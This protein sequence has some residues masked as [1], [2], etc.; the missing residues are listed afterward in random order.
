M[1]VSNGERESVPLCTPSHVHTSEEGSETRDTVHV[2]AHETRGESQT[3][4]FCPGAGAAADAAAPSVQDRRSSESE[5]REGRPAYYP[6]HR[7]KLRHGGESRARAHA[8]AIARAEARR[9]DLAHP[10]QRYP[11][12]SSPDVVHPGGND[13]H[14]H[15]CEQQST[16]QDAVD[17]MQQQQDGEDDRVRADHADEEQ[18][19][20]PADEHGTD[21]RSDGEV[22]RVLHRTRRRPVSGSD[23]AG[24]PEEELETGLSSLSS[25]TSSSLSS[26][27]SSSSS[28]CSCSSQQTSKG[29]HKTPSGSSRTKTRRRSYSSKQPSSSKTELSKASRDTIRH[30]ERSRRRKTKDT[31]DRHCQH[32]SSRSSSSISSSS[33]RCR[34][35]SDRAPDAGSRAAQS[36]LTVTTRCSP[37]A[38]IS[39]TPPAAA[40]SRPRSISPLVLRSGSE[41]SVP[42]SCP[43]ASSE[44]ASTLTCSSS[45]CSSS[46]SSSSSVSSDLAAS[47]TPPSSPRTVT[48]SSSALHV[49]CQT[50]S[51]SSSCVRGVSRQSHL[52]T[53]TNARVVNSCDISRSAMRG[54]LER[55]GRIT[56]SISLV[57]PRSC[58]SLLDLPTEIL[59]HAF[60]Y[61][62]AP[63]LCALALVNHELYEI[64]QENHLWRRV[65]ARHWGF[66]AD[67]LKS[68]HHWKYHFRL[69]YRQLTQPREK[70]RKIFRLIPHLSGHSPRGRSIQEWFRNI[71]QQ[72]HQ[73]WN[74]K[75]DFS[76]ALSA[77]RQR[78]G[79]KITGPTP[80]ILRHADVFFAT[81]P[82]V[83][84]AEIVALFDSPTL[85]LWINTSSAGGLDGGW[86]LRQKLPFDRALWIQERSPP[87]AALKEWARRHRIEFVISVDRDVG[88]QPRQTTFRFRLPPGTPLEQ[89]RVA[90]HAFSNFGYPPLPESIHHT[91]LR[92]LQRNNWSS[93]TTPP[94]N[95]H[96][97]LNNQ[98]CSSNGSSS[99]RTSASS[100][101]SSSS[102]SLASTS[103]KHAMNSRK[104]HATA[105]LLPG[106]ATEDDAPTC[107]TSLRPSRASPLPHRQAWRPSTPKL[108]DVASCHPQR[109]ASA[110]D[111][112]FAGRVTSQAASTLSFSA[113]L[114]S[115]SPPSQH[116]TSTAGCHGP[117]DEL[118]PYNALQPSDSLEMAITICTEGVVSIA[119]IAPPP[120]DLPSVHSILGV[121][122]I[123]AEDLQL[124]RVINERHSSKLEVDK[125]C[126]RQVRYQYLGDGF[127]YGVFLEGFDV[128]L[129]FALGSEFGGEYAKVHSK[130]SHKT[131]ALHNNSNRRILQQPTATSSSKPQQPNHHP[132]NASSSSK[133]QQPH[134]H[135][136]NNKC[137][138]I[139][140]TANAAASTL[141]R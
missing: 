42:R 35:E 70:L 34:C 76:L 59:L 10:A 13:E 14:A 25:S 104:D 68:P 8:N 48:P 94:R 56:K 62:D 40:T 108:P 112:P 109:A 75:V 39:I 15:S 80:L 122:P 99:T 63:S 33:Q 11:H 7:R 140:Q 23:H 29:K 51:V 6:H 105:P 86:S 60:S 124:A 141:D 127:G 12:F 81:L 17:P 115:S 114:R 91:I 74:E 82:M 111:G 55:I 87:R 50:T 130:S 90:T 28:S 36:G 106:H 103:S 69:Q 54:V 123:P 72:H 125:L 132:A 41:A 131:S 9:T 110:Q 67:L 134:H 119:V 1:E 97:A 21:S 93:S 136:A 47:T 27:A 128:W 79:F 43:H 84:L 135:P 46:S 139:Q 96:C 49:Q 92:S 65:Y 37:A 3:S 120:E 107:E 88:V 61:L 57:S 83:R 66:P 137:I 138:I 53:T 45:P 117:N 126:P 98:S 44:T 64:L 133:P 95:T 18:R 38:A 73:A 58:C 121:V 26:S 20:A 71:P 30:S 78:T 4:D 89:L 24:N 52:S 116:S 100:S 2:G 32:S 77:D 113:E 101:S 118:P 31:D 5:T 129:E 19:G 16:D 22:E 102:I 85:G